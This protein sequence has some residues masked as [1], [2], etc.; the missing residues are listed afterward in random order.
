MGSEVG[1][2]ME[3]GNRTIMYGFNKLG[4]VKE[5][6]EEVVERLSY[7]ARMEKTSDTA[8]VGVKFARVALEGYIWVSKEKWIADVLSR[9]REISEMDYSL[10]TAEVVIHFAKVYC[11]ERVVYGFLR[12]TNKDNHGMPDDLW[13]RIGLT[14]HMLDTLKP[15]T[16]QELVR[17]HRRYLRDHEEDF[18]ILSDY[19]VFLGPRVL[20][21]LMTLL[22]YGLVRME[23]LDE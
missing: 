15:M 22:E 23:R 4:T 11:L 18:L 13:A 21:N 19:I 14:C 5:W 8:E 1:N 20:A 17:A 3:K 16:F 6:K 9:L 10:L 2:F 7:L 12:V